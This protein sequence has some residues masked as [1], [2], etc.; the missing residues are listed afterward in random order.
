[1]N[2][3]DSV[4]GPPRIRLLELLHIDHDWLKDNPQG[5][6]IVQCR[7]CGIIDIISDASV[8]DDMMDVGLDDQ[9]S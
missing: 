5:S 3:V 2:D 8:M 6:L 1:L 4:V 9:A 7:L